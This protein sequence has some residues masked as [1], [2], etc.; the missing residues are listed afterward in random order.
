[1]SKQSLVNNRGKPRFGQQHSKKFC[2]IESL[3]NIVAHYTSNDGNVFLEIFM[4]ENS[5]IIALM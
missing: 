3:R 4:E 2:V 5:L 1:M